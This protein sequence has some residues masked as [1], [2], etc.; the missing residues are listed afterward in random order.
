MSHGTVRGD[1]EEMDIEEEGVVAVGGH[2]PH[3]ENDWILTED[4]AGF[5]HIALRGGDVISTHFEKSMSS[6]KMRIVGKYVFRGMDPA[7]TDPWNL[8]IG[9]GDTAIFLQEKMQLADMVLHHVDQVYAST[10]KADTKAMRELEKMRL[11]HARELAQLNVRLQASGDNVGVAVGDAPTIVRDRGGDTNVP[12]GRMGKVVHGEHMHGHDNVQHM[13]AREHTTHSSQSRKRRNSVTSSD[14]EGVTFVRGKA[15]VGDPPFFNGTLGARG[16]AR[17]CEQWMIAMEEYLDLC[18]TRGEARAMVAASWLKGDAETIY[19]AEQKIA[20]AARIPI[21]FAFMC[22]V[23]RRAF[24]PRAQ[25]AREY[26]DTLREWFGNTADLD[27]GFK[28]EDVLGRYQQMVHQLEGRLEAAGASMEG[29]FRSFALLAMCPVV[30]REA[31]WLDAAQRPVSDV[32]TLMERMR[33]EAP[34][35]ETTAQQAASVAKRAEGR[36]AAR[37]S[38]AG[39]GGS[40]DRPFKRPF[41][42]TFKAKGHNGAGTSAG[43]SQPGQGTGGGKGHQGGG[44]GNYGASGGAGRKGG[45]EGKPAFGG[46]HAPGPSAPARQKGGAKDMARRCD[47]CGS[48]DH[49]KASQR[50]PEYEKFL[51][52]QLAAVQK[53]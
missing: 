38:S 44:N 9:S 45:D 35:L 10:G 42:S 2:A 6:G 34:H 15:K 29:C 20:K 21:T 17:K 3:A 51:K 8:S 30:V 24:V 13:R 33:E 27:A 50:C 26:M 19:R 48:T 22:L 16:M 53:R 46:M 40:Q 36:M 4:P 5:I 28:V 41:P 32:Q 52:E 23:L 49:L 12:A 39:S 14:D 18:G 7:R 31:L 43:H 37:P 11:T 25:A 47:N 1:H